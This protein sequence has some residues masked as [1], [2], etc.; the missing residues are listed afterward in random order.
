MKVFYKKQKPK[1]IQYRSYKKRYQ[2]NDN[3]V[4]Q[5]E[6]NSELLKI[7][8][9]NADLSEFTEIFQSILDKH[10]P[11]KQKFIRAN[12]PSFVTKN[13]RKAIM[14]SLKLRNKYL[15]ERTNEAKS[16]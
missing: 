9:N 15:H 8:L 7:D 3:Q 14:K 5:R 1:I 6:L 12:N 4:F 11:K 13:L 10:A 16:L 2:V